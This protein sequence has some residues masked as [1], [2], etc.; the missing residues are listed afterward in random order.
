MLDADVDAFG[1]DA[2]PDLFVDDDADGAGVDVEDSSGPA[3]VVLVGHALVDG[4]VYY[5]IHYISDFVGS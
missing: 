5:N 4:A 3:V 2:L 1:D